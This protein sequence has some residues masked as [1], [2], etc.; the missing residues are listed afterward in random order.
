MKEFALPETWTRVKLGD[1]AEIVGGGTPSRSNRAYFGGDIPWAT[2]T[3]ITSLDTLWIEET[4]ETI[5]EEGLNNSSAKLLPEGT[6]LMAS[7][8]TIGV[9]DPKE[10]RATACRGPEGRGSADCASAVSA[11]RPRRQASTP[12]PFA[13]PDVRGMNRDLAFQ[14]RWGVPRSR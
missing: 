3:D 10:T 5:T 1:I 13:D 9:S 7:R 8:A 14:A 12:S 11:L 4:A 6:V 2:P